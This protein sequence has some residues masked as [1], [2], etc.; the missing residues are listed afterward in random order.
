MTVTGL[1]PGDQI[2]VPCPA[3]SP[4]T[5]AVHEVLKP[6]AHATVRCRLCDHTHKTV[7]EEE[8]RS[9][10]RVVVSSEGESIRTTASVPEDEILAIGEEFVAETEEGPMGVRITSLEM[11]DGERMDRAPASDIQTIWTRAVDNVAV[12]TTVHPA[13]GRREGT[14]SETYYLPG[15]ELITIGEAMPLSDGDVKVER[16]LLR[17]DVATDMPDNLDHPGTQIL[18]KDAKRVFARRIQADTWKS[19]WE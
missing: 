4:S 18:A 1:E 3:C 19:P 10:T 9:D 14:I 15:D 2:R 12:S 5:A 16:I 11:S 7:L 6:D 13:D 8:Q 17:D